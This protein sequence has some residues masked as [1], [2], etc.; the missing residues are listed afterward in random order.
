MPQSSGTPSRQFYE[1]TALSSAGV[2][3]NGVLKT[4]AHGAQLIDMRT[5]LQFGHRIVVFMLPKI[6][7]AELTEQ[8][9]EELRAKMLSADAVQPLQYREHLACALHESVKVRQTCF[10][11]DVAIAAAVVA[12]TAAFSNKKKEAS[13][14]VGVGTGADTGAGTSAEKKIA[15]EGIDATIAEEDARVSAS[16]FKQG[17]AGKGLGWEEVDDVAVERLE[18]LES[19]TVLCGIHELPSFARPSASPV[20]A[21]ASATAA[22][23]TTAVTDSEQPNTINTVVDGNTESAAAAMKKKKPPKKTKVALT[24]LPAGPQD[25]HGK[26]GR[27]KGEGGGG[28]GEDGVVEAAGGCRGFRN[29]SCYGVERF[30]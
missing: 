26:E 3:V 20:P 27:G 28:R 9:N 25:E 1:V 18:A 21:R 8:A 16:D 14:G 5:V 11:R 30:S 7:P 17:G 12:A 15:E 29:T 2:F 22:I 4:P 23:A 19:H 24:S 13:E 10:D 6:V